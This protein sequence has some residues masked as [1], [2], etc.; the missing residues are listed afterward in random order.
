MT[1]FQIEQTAS[2]IILGIFE[3]NSEAEALDAMAQDAGY[4]DFAEACEVSPMGTDTLLMTKV[5]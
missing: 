1:K 3:G 4:R 2:G 5:A